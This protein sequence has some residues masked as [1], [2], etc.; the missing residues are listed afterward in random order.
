MVVADYQVTGG[1][2]TTRLITAAGGTARF[3]HADVSNESDVRA[4]VAVA[5]DE[6]GRVDYL[7]NNAGIA[8]A[9]PAAPLHEVETAAFEKVQDVNVTGNFL[10][11]KH[12]IP[13]MLQ[14][15]GGSIVNVSSVAGARGFAGDPSYCTSKHALLGLTKSAALTYAKQGI[16][17]NV[18]GPGIVFT[19]MTEDILED[20]Q[21]KQWLLGVTPQ[22]RYAAPEEIAKLIVFLCSDDA[23]FITG[24]YYPADGGWL[25]G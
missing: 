20:E 15:G 8:A 2:E 22:G 19:G 10:G 3:V 24:A 7:V 23:S 18:V 13:A 9:G 14:S 21:Q 17:V 12:A 11:M 1:E 5:V 16:R 25:A 6:F 4:M